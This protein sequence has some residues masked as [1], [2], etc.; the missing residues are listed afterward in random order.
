MLQRR[1]QRDQRQIVHIIGKQI[2][3]DNTH[4]LDDV[5]ISEASPLES[6]YVVNDAAHEALRRLM[7]EVDFDPLRLEN[8][9]ARFRPF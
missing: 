2:H 6:I 7:M 9:I 1:L 8:E 4:D 5:G 3:C